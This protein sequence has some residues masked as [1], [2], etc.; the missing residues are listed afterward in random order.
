MNATTLELRRDQ[1]APFF[2]M[3]DK[4]YQGWAVTV[5]AL[6]GKLGDQPEANGV[7]FQ[8]ISFETKGSRAGDILIEAGDIGT[9]YI[10]HDVPKPKIVRVSDTQPGA[11]MDI[12]V[13]SEEGTV[14]IIR[15][16]RRQELPPP[17]SSSP[18]PRR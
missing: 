8:G 17:P 4:E 2:N 7:P 13:E 11:E 5:E 10:V 3:V 15:L 14:R 16:R 12:Q 18:P 9:P 1:W 6:L